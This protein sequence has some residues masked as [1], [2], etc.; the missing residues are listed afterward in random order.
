MPSAVSS[1]ALDA[2]LTSVSNGSERSEFLRHSVQPFDPGNSGIEFTIE[3]PSLRK[4]SIA[5]KELACLPL[6]SCRVRS[7]SVL[8]LCSPP[9]GQ[10]HDGPLGDWAS[11]RNLASP[12]SSFGGYSRLSSPGVLLVVVRLR[13]YAPRIFLE[14]GFIAASDGF[15]AIAVAILPAV[16]LPLS[17]DSGSVI[18]Y[19]CTHLAA[20][21]P[22][23]PRR[24]HQDD[25]EQEQRPDQQE[26]LRARRG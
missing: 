5:P 26:S 12:G 10:R 4:A 11:S 6:R 17:K 13:C 15:I 18:A 23:G 7:P 9:S 24:V 19:L 14:G 2:S 22:I 21:H 16:I 20:E 8:P 3:R 25:R 1:G